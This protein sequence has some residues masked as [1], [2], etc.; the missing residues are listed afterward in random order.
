M[1]LTE[2]LYSHLKQ[3]ASPPYL[4]VGSGISRRYL[5][6]ENWAGLLEK[7]CK[8]HGLDH[9]FLSTSANGSLPA[10]ATEMAR[11][12]HETWWKDKKYK[13]S[14]EKYSS[15]AIN[16]ESALKIEIA[17]Y[18]SES[19]ST[20]TKDPKLVEELALFRNIVVD[21]IVT[22]NWDELLETLFPDYKVYVGQEALLFAQIQGIG[23]V[24]KIHG[25]CIDPS[26]LVLTSN[27]YDQFDKRNP[28]LASKLLTFFVENPIVF[29]GYSLADQNILDIIHSV[30][31][32][33]SPG[34]VE[35]L[36]DRLVF[37]QWDASSKEDRF[38][39]TI[40]ASDGRSLPV[41]Q[42]TTASMSSVLEALTK[43]QRK[44]PAKI[45]RMLKKQVFDLVHTTTPSS[46]LFV[47]DIDASTDLTKLE[48]AIGVGIQERLRDKGYTALSRHDLVRDVLFNDGS[49]RADLI[50]RDTLPEILKKTPNVSVFKYIKAASE[51]SPDFK[52]SSLNSRVVKASKAKL[53]TFSPTNV[54]PSTAAAIRAYPKDFGAYSKQNDAETVVN[55][56]GKLSETALKPAQLHKF[57]TDNIDLASSAKPNVVTNYFKLV[58]IYDFL[59]YGRG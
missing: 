2:Q 39:R 5:G 29:L 23:E 4:F 36:A 49:Y 55:Y 25:S 56:A 42:V 24:Y 9:G 27:D 1:S 31:A 37:I 15:F 3:F 33:L 20:L 45:L 54:S 16:R 59:K 30:L 46:K 51:G 21:G 43:I 35:K 38:E 13:I 32:C 18:I 53:D 52:K 34:N 28:Y 47:Q 50:V 8:V 57:L 26:S 41:Y 6:L 7:Q 19:G 17:K 10:L 22:T 14:R 12:L 44:I 11:E 58:C 40:L 48:F